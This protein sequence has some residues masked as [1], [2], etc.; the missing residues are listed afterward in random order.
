MTSGAA[1]LRHFFDNLEVGPPKR[2]SIRLARSR[3]RRCRTSRTGSRA[4]A[5]RVVLRPRAVSAQADRGADETPS[6]RR[7]A[8]GSV[9]VQVVRPV[10]VD[11]AGD[12]DRVTDLRFVEEGQQPGGS[13]R[14][15]ATGPCWGLRSPGMRSAGANMTCWA[16]T[17]QVAFDRQA[18]DEP[19][20]PARRR[21]S[22]PSGRG[23][24]SHGGCCR[25]RRAGRC[26]TAAYRAR[27][28]R[29]GRRSETWR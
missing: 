13:P 5:V 11:L 15:R 28:T 3:A 2:A 22:S 26:G 7:G 20:S 25:R 17:F 6:R 8:S 10:G 23:R 16:S 21:A 9:S 12:D 4:S 29:R 14:S 27:R 19:V 1:R 18:V 24:P